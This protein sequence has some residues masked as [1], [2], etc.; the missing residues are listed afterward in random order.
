[1]DD[2]GDAALAQTNH[3]SEEVNS[4]LNNAMEIFAKAAEESIRNVPLVLQDAPYV[5]VALR[6][7]NVLPDLGDVFRD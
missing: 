1:M 7:L 5:F 3:I 6:G 2:K 4:Y